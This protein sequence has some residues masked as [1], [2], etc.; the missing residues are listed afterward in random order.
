VNEAQLLAELRP[1]IRAEAGERLGYR[2]RHHAEDAAQ[3]AWITL[4]KAL[5]S[6]HG[7]MPFIPWCHGVVRNRIL[8]YINRDMVPTPIPPAPGR[9]SQPV[10]IDCVEDVSEIWEGEAATEDVDLA[11]HHAELAAALDTLSPKL[12]AYVEARFWQGLRGAELDAAVG[13]SNATASLWNG[14]RKGR[15]QLTRALAHL[16]Q[17]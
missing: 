13:Q 9:P 11:Y 4:W 2:D 1:W 8:N 5:P 3:E 14:P 15:E 6:Y 10:H 12:R 7:Q 16:A 17:V